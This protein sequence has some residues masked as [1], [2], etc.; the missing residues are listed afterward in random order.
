MTPLLHICQLRCPPTHE[1]AF[2][3]NRKQPGHYQPGGPSAWRSGVVPEWREGQAVHALRAGSRGLLLKPLLDLVSFS[4]HSDLHSHA[5]LIPFISGYLVWSR[6]KETL[7]VPSASPL[8]AVIPLAVGLPALRALLFGDSPAASFRPNDYL[9]LASVSFVCFLGSGGA[10][11]LG[12]E[13]RAG[14]AGS[15]RLKPLKDAREAAER[16]IIVATLKRHKGKIAPSAAELEI[17]R[18]TLY[19]LIEKLRVQK[20]QASSEGGVPT[21]QVARNG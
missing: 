7:P 14:A 8:L 17:S 21:P 12:R 2:A 20:P 9:A 5:V 11:T 19:E 16:E 1:G 13:T 10:P 6:R 3:R 18:P 4:L 15:L